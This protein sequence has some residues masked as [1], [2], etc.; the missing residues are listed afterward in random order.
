MCLVIPRGDHPEKEQ[1]D[2]NILTHAIFTIVRQF[3]RRC[4]R[5][6]ST[7]PKTNQYSFRPQEKIDTKK[8]NHFHRGGRNENEKPE[9]PLKLC[10]KWKTSKKSV[11][12]TRKNGAP[13]KFILACYSFF[14]FYRHA[15]YTR[16]IKNRANL[17]K[18]AN[19]KFVIRTSFVVLCQFIYLIYVRYYYAR[20]SVEHAYTLYVRYERSNAHYRYLIIRYN[21]NYYCNCSPTFKMANVLVD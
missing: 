16:T 7:R 5:P 17:T 2:N 6:I 11:G 8:K 15:L 14:F 18:H 12:T 19:K 10:T 9:K 3:F 20:Y 13:P 4:Q 21:N 1:I